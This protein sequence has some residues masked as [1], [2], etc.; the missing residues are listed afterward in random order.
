MKQINKSHSNNTYGLNYDCFKTIILYNTQY[1]VNLIKEGVFPEILKNS[2]II[3]ILKNKSNKQGLNNY[4]P[5]TITPIFSKIIEKLAHN[6]IYNFL[7]E[8]KLINTNQYGFLKN[9]STNS[10]LDMFKYNIVKNLE[11]KNFYISIFFD[12]SKAFDCINFDLFEKL[13]RLNFSL[14][15]I[16]WIES[17]IKNRNQVVD[18]NGVQSKPLIKARGVTQG[19]ILGP[20]LFILFINDFPINN[21]KYDTLICADNILISFPITNGNYEQINND[22]NNELNS[23]NNWFESHCLMLIQIKL[24]ILFSKKL[25]LISI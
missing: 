6:Q 20:L 15:S 13:H 1:F 21:N 9:K 3:P 12:L 24:I 2:K 16:E 8:N 17:Y 7:D 5:I 11:L 4:R 25:I 22:I 14:L 10:C 23:I 18:L 19:S